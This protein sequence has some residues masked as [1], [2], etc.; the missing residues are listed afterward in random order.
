MVGAGVFTTSGFALA[1]LGT[2]GRVLAAWLV[3]GLA[4][5]CGALCYGALGRRFPESGGEYHLLRETVHPLAG[6]LAGWVSLLA[7]F[8]APT[9]AAALGLQAYLAPFLGDVVDPRW[10]GTGAVAL[11]CLLHGSRVATGVVAQN[12]AVA[13]KLVLLSGFV[14][15]GGWTLLTG[16]DAGGAPPAPP[17]PF[18]WGAFAVSLV[19]IGFAYS[20]WNAAV[21]VAGELRDPARDLHRSLLLGAGAVTL[22]YLGLN[23]VFLHAAPVEALAGRAEVG[24]VAAEALGGPALNRAVSALVALALFTSVSSLVMLGPRVYARMAEDGLFP[25]VF[26]PGAGAPAAAVALQGGLAVLVI[27]LSEL[28]ELLGYLGFTLGISAA[29]TVLGLVRQRRRE[30]PEALPVPLWPLPP[31]LFLLATLGSAAFLLLRRPAES[32][33]GLLTVLAGVPVW[34]LLRRGGRTAGDAAAPKA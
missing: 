6:F 26:R 15:L 22:L 4:A 20:G 17:P 34:W 23:A 32:L 3:G 25:R 27:W 21:Y 1:D 18:E 28:A 19:W 7:G 12:L 14:L 30:G 29:A 5:L 8:T 2:P 16:A 24:A 13:L 31:L 33:G 9:A 10:I 11:A